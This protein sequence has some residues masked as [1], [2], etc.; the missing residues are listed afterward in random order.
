M[1]LHH[2]RPVLIATFLVSA[3]GAGTARAQGPSDGRIVGRV[4]DAAS[5]AGLSDAGIQIVGTT[6]GALSARGAISIA[7]VTPLRAA[8]L[9]AAAIAS[10][11]TV[12][13]AS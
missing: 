9:A 1:R 5:G 10:A 7:S 8:A 4:I 13:T 12:R 11:A 2:H 6:I 3:L